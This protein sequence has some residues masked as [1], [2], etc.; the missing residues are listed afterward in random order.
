MVHVWFCSEL[1]LHSLRTCKDPT[2]KEQGAKAP[3]QNGLGSLPVVLETLL[4]VRGASG[5]CLG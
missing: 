1:S 2:E 5:A 3:Q 4:V